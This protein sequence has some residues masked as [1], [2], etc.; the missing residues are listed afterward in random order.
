LLVL[1]QQKAYQWVVTPFDGIHR[2]EPDPRDVAPGKVNMKAP[3]VASLDEAANI[4]RDHSSQIV[5]EPCHAARCL[6]GVKYVVHP[7]AG[8]RHGQGIQR[9]VWPSSGS[10]PV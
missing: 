2:V 5:I 4:S 6:S 9:I 1:L 7:P 8:D 3:L 10:E